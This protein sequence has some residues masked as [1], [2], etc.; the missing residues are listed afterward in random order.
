[1]E[2]NMAKTYQIVKNIDPTIF[3]GYDIRGLVGNQ[4]NED[5]YY[6]LGRAYATWLNRHRIN[7]CSVG[8]DVRL[9]GEQ[10]ADA[11]IA[12]LNDGGIN[13]INIGETL[14]PISYFSNYELKTRGGAMITASH[15]PKEYNGLKL[16]TGYSETMLTHEIIEIR[17]ICDSGKFIESEQKGA[18]TTKDILPA[19]IETVNRFFNIPKKYKI[20]VDGCCTGSGH[21]YA[22]VLRKAG[23]E[24]IEQNCEPDGNFPMGVPDPTEI[25]VL[26]R[27]AERVK[28]EKADVGFAYDADGDRIAVVD[29]NG[30]PLWMDVIV[31]IFSKSILK[32]LPGAPI[33]FNV[34]CSQ[35][36]RDT[37]T[38]EGGRPVMWITGHSFIKEKIMEERSPFGGELSG[39]IFF[40]DNYFPHDDSANASL[41]LL[42][43]MASES[44]KLSELVAELPRYIGSPEIK[45]G[46][47]DKIKFEFID[48]K[49]KKDLETLWP[50]AEFTTI[51]GVRADL[52]G[53]M[54]VIRASQNG[55]YITI[56]FEA[57][58]ESDYE[59]IKKDVRTILKS[60]PEIDWSVGVNTHSID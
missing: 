40:A 11:L 4:L 52:P 35:A 10:F 58:S 41:R 2:I 60:H 25:E 13:T 42:D 23:M 38:K 56:K 3:R 20:V 1:M 15:N 18:N 33:V 21:K 51:D 22:E 50:D 7:E 55:P 9:D 53:K 37:I 44:K 36:V 46:L 29:E 17:N 6:T 12:G 45:L 14:T 43:F 28:A 57:Q 59:Q 27:L 39:H 19:Y 31:A 34:L 26:K 47:A 30:N 5:V 32:R 24:V 8:H 16:S 48:T 49:I 54:I